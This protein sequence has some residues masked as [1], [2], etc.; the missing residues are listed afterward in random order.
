MD[1]HHRVAPEPNDGLDTL[2]SCGRESSPLAVIMGRDHGTRAVLCRLLADDGCKV[3]EAVDA[4]AVAAIAS[5]VSLLVAVADAA[6]D[7]VVGEL[8]TLRRLGYGAPAIVVARGASSTL[9]HRAFA[10]G[11]VDVI[12]FTAGAADV[13]ARLRAALEYACHGYVPAGL[14]SGRTDIQFAD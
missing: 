5:T 8:V 13:L 10:L 3:V 12:G 4:A 7:D 11:V 2:P 6:D 1:L 14:N 9:R